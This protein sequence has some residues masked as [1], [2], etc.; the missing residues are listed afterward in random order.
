MSEEDDKKFDKEVERLGLEFMRLVDA[1]LKAG[2][3]PTYVY[4]GLI[5]A[6]FGLLA[7]A[8]DSVKDEE[9]LRLMITLEKHPA[10]PMVGEPIVVSRDTEDVN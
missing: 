10:F 1:K 9:I 4:N 7:D 5:S 2:E 3:K 8:P 6:A